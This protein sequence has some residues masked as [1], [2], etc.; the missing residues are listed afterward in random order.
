[1]SS[2]EFGAKAS[3]GSLRLGFRSSL[4]SSLLK[5]AW[6]EAIGLFIANEFGL[7][8]R[9][10]INFDVTQLIVEALLVTRDEDGYASCEEMIDCKMV[11]SF[12]QAGR[13]KVSIKFTSCGSKT[14]VLRVKGHSRDILP[15]LPIQ[16]IFV[17]N[18]DS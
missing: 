12:S 15:I 4:P 9:K 8:N 5:G 18:K 1:M 13:C 17:V 10:T 14:V 3:R 16:D 11:E 7:F 6:S 2:D